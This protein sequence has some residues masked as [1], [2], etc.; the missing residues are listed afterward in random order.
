MRALLMSCLAFGIV[1]LPASAQT[2]SLTPRSGVA[3]V[4]GLRIAYDVTGTGEAVVLLHGLTLDR[5]M[6]APNLAALA[7]HYRV[8][9]I[10][11]PGAGQS[12]QPVGPASFSDIVAGVLACLGVDRAHV[13]GLSNGGEIAVNLAIE[14]PDIVRSLVL[15]DAS[16]NG[17]H[18]TPEFLGRFQ[19]YFAAA[20]HD[21]VTRANELWL[22]DPLFVPAARDSVLA[23]RLRNM[24][25]PYKG[26]A[27]LHFGWRRGITPPAISRLHTIGVPTLVIVG[28]RDIP[29]MRQIADTLATKI[30]GAR[31]IVLANVGHMSN[32]EDSTAFNRAAL[33]FLQAV[34]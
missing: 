28:E 14:H 7:D 13:V 31:E 15:V 4:Q 27:W 1:G 30:P 24:V 32:M 26:E 21:G 9:R 34:R 20:E 17:F 18:Y 5:Q 33:S 10:D 16:L 12:D 8:I 25:M 23:R 2:T 3:T 6:W 29:D 19:A 22:A 11:L